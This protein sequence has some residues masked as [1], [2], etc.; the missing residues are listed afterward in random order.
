MKAEYPE[1]YNLFH[2]N[3]IADQKLSYEKISQKEGLSQ[4]AIGMKLRN[5]KQAV[6]EHSE[7]ADK[8]K[9]II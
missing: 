1:H 8:R 7:F 6:R 4:Y 5:I 9:A 2:S 3:M